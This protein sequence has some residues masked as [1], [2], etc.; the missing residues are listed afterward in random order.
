MEGIV[1]LAGFGHRFRL[2]YWISVYRNDRFRHPP[3]IP[4]APLPAGGGPG[5]RKTSRGCERS[6]RG[7]RTTVSAR[8]LSYV[9]VTAD[10]RACCQ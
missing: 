8:T 7:S 10:R 4:R 2:L 5:K 9:A 6:A 3:R 1:E